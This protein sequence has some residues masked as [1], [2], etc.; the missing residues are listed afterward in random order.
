MI[1]TV[2]YLPVNEYG[3]Y[4][5]IQ[6][7]ISLSSF[8]I[9]QNLFLYT[10]LKISG[11]ETQIQY[12]YLRTLLIMVISAFFIGVGGMY[13]LK[14]DKFVWGFFEIDADFA[15]YTLIIL[16]IIIINNELLR[17]FI[18]VKKVEFNNYAQ[19]FQKISMLSAVCVLH[20]Y[21][22]LTLNSF[23]MFYLLSNGLILIFL[24]S[25][26][27][28]K[29]LFFTAIFKYDVIQK[30][31]KVVL[32]LIPMNLMGF[33][34]NYTDTLM[35]GKF[36][37]TEYVAKYGF[38]SQIITMVKV[39]VGSSVI[40][41]LFPYATEANNKQDIVL[42]NRILIQ[43]IKYSALLTLIA[44]SLMVV[45]ANWVLKL[46]H[47]DQYL[48]VSQYLTVYGVL[49]IFYV[50]FSTCGHHLQLL[51]IFNKQMV[52]ATIVSIENI[53]LNGILINKY[54]VMGATY[55]TVISVMTLAGLFFYTAIQNDAAFFTQL[56][57]S[58]QYFI[59]IWGLAIGLFIGAKYL[60][61]LQMMWVI[62]VDLAIVMGAIM[63]GV[64]LFRR[65]MI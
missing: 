43:M 55:S 56:K 10:R 51:H 9:S 44:Y 15:L 6:G 31:Y 12:S 17:F 64:K 53:V 25:K 35:I 39:T 34:L 21:D 29:S 3:I 36:I 52:F 37:G 26:L 2:K 32:P 27:D 60:Q 24:V 38:A 22:F 4:V 18:A 28:L 14:A 61:N 42:R 5:L 46:L 58:K 19:F 45:N 1:L 23:L 59:P 11:S 13:F 50:L 62:G 41:T 30:G 33:I 47:L 63:V 54:G 16:L 48:D 57:N 8:I 40:T 7:F 20:I 65:N 49:P